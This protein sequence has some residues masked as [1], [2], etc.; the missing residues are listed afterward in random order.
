MQFKY[1][2]NTVA[3]LDLNVMH[4]LQG[5]QRVGEQIKSSG[6]CSFSQLNYA[7]PPGLRTESQMSNSLKVFIFIGGVWDNFIVIFCIPGHLSSCV[8]HVCISVT[9]FQCLFLSLCLSSQNQSHWSLLGWRKSSGGP[10]F[11]LRWACPPLA[12]IPLEGVQLNT[13]PG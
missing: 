3:F 2:P 13:I 10:S 5:I 8:L 12:V 11:L 1:F 9:L 6:V 4:S 7:L